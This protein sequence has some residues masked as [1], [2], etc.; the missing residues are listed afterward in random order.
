M[1]STITALCLPIVWS[2][3]CFLFSHLKRWDQHLEFGHIST[4]QFVLRAK[5]QFANILRRNILFQMLQGWQNARGA[6][7][8]KLLLICKFT[9]HRIF[10]SIFLKI[11]IFFWKKT[12]EKSLFSHGFKMS[13]HFASS[14]HNKC[15]TQV[16]TA[17]SSVCWVLVGHAVGWFPIPPRSPRVP[18]FTDLLPKFPT[19]FQTCP[20]SG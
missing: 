6:L 9:P 1:F 7:K 14:R 3:H 10:H 17:V 11:S 4:V 16:P 8:T 12:G 2:V 13:G 5:L 20:S 15:L 19:Y 18:Y